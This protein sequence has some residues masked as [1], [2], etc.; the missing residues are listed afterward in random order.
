MPDR[1]LMGPSAVEDVAF[2]SDGPLVL[3]SARWLQVTFEVD[4]QSALALLPSEVGRPIPPYGRLLVASSPAGDIALLSV[5]GRFRMM[6]RNVM[7]AAIAGAAIEGV[8]RGT[9]GSGTVQGTV[10]LSRSGGEVTATVGGAESSLVSVKLPDIFAIE[11]TMLRWDALVA[12]ARVDGAAVIAEVTPAPELSAAFL[13]KGATIEVERSLPPANPWRALRS[14]GII[15]ACYAEGT[16]TFGAPQV[17][18][19]WS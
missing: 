2:T 7:V 1:G 12:F 3:E 17:Q 9:F 19:T 11:P 18:Q 6:P 5:G 14:L 16:L 4:R 15:S 13:S 10:S 8:V